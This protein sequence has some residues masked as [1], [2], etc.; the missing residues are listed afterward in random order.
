MFV[1]SIFSEESE[2]FL[3]QFLLTIFLKSNTL[4]LYVCLNKDNMANVRIQNFA[5]HLGI[6]SE[7]HLCRTGLPNI[8]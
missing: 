4:C 7:L 3:F 2:N 8:I 1:F 6:C 5:S